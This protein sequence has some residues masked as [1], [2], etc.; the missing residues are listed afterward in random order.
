MLADS[1]LFAQLGHRTAVSFTQNAD[2][3][4]FGKSSLF[5]SSFVVE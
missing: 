5:I 2:H 4:L 1:M 3:L